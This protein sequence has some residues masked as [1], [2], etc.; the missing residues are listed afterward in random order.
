MLAGMGVLAAADQWI[1]LNALRLVEACVV[2]NIEYTKLIYA[3]FIGYV[4]FGEI[5]D[6][7]TMIGAVVIIGSSAHLLHREMKIKAAHEN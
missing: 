7:Y 3:V 6:F 4:V 5:P 1:G 2:G